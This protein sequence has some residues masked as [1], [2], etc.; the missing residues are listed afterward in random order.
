MTETKRKMLIP[1]LDGA[2]WGL[3]RPLLEAGVLSHLVAL[4]RAGERGS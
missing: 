1:G 3:L 2:K 4:T